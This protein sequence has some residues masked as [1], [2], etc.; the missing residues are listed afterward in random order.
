MKTTKQIAQQAGIKKYRAIPEDFQLTVL[1]DERG[2]PYTT[3][4]SLTVEQQCTMSA[5]S[6][7]VW[8]SHCADEL[9]D[10]FAARYL[11]PQN[12]LNI[13]SSYEPDG[14]FEVW[15]HSRIPLPKKEITAP[16]QQKCLALSDNETYID[17]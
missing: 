14:R 6:I 7:Q 3:R 15:L 8:L 4:V 13:L 16:A 5:L 11:I 1:L 2:R 17:I 12:Q 10:L 9:R